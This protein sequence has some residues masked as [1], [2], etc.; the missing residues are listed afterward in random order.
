M[1]ERPPIY[2]PAPP[3]IPV[4]PLFARQREGRP[5]YVLEQTVRIRTVAGWVRI[6]RGYVTDF[7]SIPGLAQLLTLL[8]LQPLGRHAWAALAHDWLY[9]IGEPGQRPRADAVFRARMAL[10]G[11]GAWRREVMYRAV[12]LGGG[13]GY[14]QAP[15]WWATLNFA[16]PDAGDYPL[17]PPFARPEAYAGQRWGLRPDPEWIEA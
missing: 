5:L 10:D 8:N 12:R 3:V 4:R 2:G 14:E 6:P 11:V 7:G 17:A 13:G 1:I 15:T 9:A 16:D